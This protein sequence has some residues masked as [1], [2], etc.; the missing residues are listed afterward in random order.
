MIKPGY[1]DI[2]SERIPVVK[3]SD[4]KVTIKVIAGEAMG[5]KAVIETQ[6]KI[7][8][9]DIHIQAGSE[10]THTLPE[11]YSGFAYVWRGAGK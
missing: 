11:S 1:Q 6:T 4:D 5:T 2:P 9:L 7:L 3:T 10:Y 8:F